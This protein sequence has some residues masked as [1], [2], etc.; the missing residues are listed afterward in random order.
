MRLLVDT[1]V[2]IAIL[3]GQVEVDRAS[4]HEYFTCGPVVQEV[5]QGFGENPLASRY[6][7]RLLKVPRLSDPLPSELFVNAAD[8]YRQG[9]R[10][11]LTIRSAAECLIAAIALENGATIW[12]RDRDFD[13]IAQFTNLKVRRSLWAN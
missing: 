13:N 7:D 6:Q 8:I 3:R 12:H 9:R 11:G 4:Y 2:W 10:R 1:S 5:L